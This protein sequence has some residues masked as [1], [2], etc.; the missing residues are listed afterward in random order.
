MKKALFFLPL[1]LF[2]VWGLDTG[3]FSRMILRPVKPFKPLPS[4]TAPDYDKKESWV[5]RPDFYNPGLWPLNQEKVQK[6]LRVDVFYIHPT[7]FWRG[8]DWNF[9]LKSSN[10]VLNRIDEVIS[11]H[12][13]VFNQCCRIFAPHY[14]EA[15]LWSFKK[16][17]TEKGRKALDFAY[18]DV[19]RAFDHFIERHHQG[20]PFILA[21]HSQ[22][23]AHALRL[24]RERIDRTRLQGK[25]VAGYLLGYKLPM[26]YFKRMV[27]K[28]GPCQNKTDTQ[29]LVHWDAYERGGVLKKKRGLHWYPSGWEFADGKEALCTNPLSWRVDEEFMGEGNHHGLASSISEENVVIGPQKVWAQCENGSLFVKRMEDFR[30]YVWRFLNWSRTLKNNNLHFFDYELFYQDIKDNAAERIKKYWDLEEE[31]GYY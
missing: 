14:R 29:C 5:A 8:T 3:Y 7:T 30:Y 20:R 28:I 21:S 27:K 15:T 22:G 6:D 1:L 10:L 23:T 31:K 2:I 13:S 16:P 9:D 26:D 19:L 24:I 25:F 12:A 18:K 4:K 17:D 11:N